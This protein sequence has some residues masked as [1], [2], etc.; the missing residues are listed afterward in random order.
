MRR[1][2]AV[3]CHMLQ[4][5]VTAVLCAAGRY[6]VPSTCR[7]PPVPT[8]RQRT[9]LSGVWKTRECSSSRAGA[10]HP[11]LPQPVA[12]AQA[13]TVQDISTFFCFKPASLSRIKPAS[14]LYQACKACLSS[15]FSSHPCP[16]RTPN[17]TAGASCQ[18]NST[19]FLPLHSLHHSSLLITT[20]PRESSTLTSC[21][22]TCT[23][24]FV[25]HTHQTIH[26]T[27]PPVFIVAL[28]GT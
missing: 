9:L 28:K 15:L 24:T 1:G 21:A 27:I 18:K 22:V 5:A 14:L 3:N 23:S 13:F 19:P 26:S 11:W 16:P 8:Q 10:G 12:G 6:F 20:I 2:W 4:P 25:P 7:L 17:P